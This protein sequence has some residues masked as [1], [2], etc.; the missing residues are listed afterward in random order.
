[1][2]GGESWG[3]EGT[4][5]ESVRLYEVTNKTDLMPMLKQRVTED[6]VKQNA[7]DA[8]AKEEAEGRCW[9]N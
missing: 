7:T 9:K 6:K 4:I 1:L 5:P 2:S 8:K 3:N